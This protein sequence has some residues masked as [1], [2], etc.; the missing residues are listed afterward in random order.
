AGRDVRAV[1]VDY[2]SGSPEPTSR[3]PGRK[4]R[5]NSRIFGPRALN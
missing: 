1:D 3:P 4:M 2:I 5:G